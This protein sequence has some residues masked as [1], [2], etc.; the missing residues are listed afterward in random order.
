MLSSCSNPCALAGLVKS[1]SGA[2]RSRGDRVACMKDLEV[3]LV[4]FQ[5]FEMLP[6]LILAMPGEESKTSAP[7]TLHLLPWMS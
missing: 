7:N 2:S 4:L 6:L 3:K 5:E 1:N